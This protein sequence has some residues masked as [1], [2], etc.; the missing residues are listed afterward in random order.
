MDIDDVMNKLNLNG[1]ERKFF[2]EKLAEQPI[3]NTMEN[4][5]RVANW[6]KCK[7]KIEKNKITK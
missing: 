4:Y 7:T 5:E 3:Y 2:M 1:I 6:A